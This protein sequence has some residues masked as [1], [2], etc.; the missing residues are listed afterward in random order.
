[1]SLFGHRVPDQASAV[2]VGVRL[3]S[4]RVR[5]GVSWAGEVDGTC[6]RQGRARHGRRTRAGSQPRAPAGG[7]G[8][9][10]HRARHLR[11][12]SSRRHT[13]LATPDDLAETVDAVKAPT[14]GTCHRRGRRPRRRRRK[15]ALDA[16][17]SQL[18]RL[19]IVCANAGIGFLRARSELSEQAWTEMIDINLSGAW[20]TTKAAIAH[21]RTAAR[22]CSRARSP[23]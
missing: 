6:R 16:G 23:G 1:M 18:G 12:R 15:A 10:H 2:V 7:G 3:L 9:R 17:V 11:R 19:D 20:H 8:R 14:A 5:L 13:P 21:T 4:A 22:S